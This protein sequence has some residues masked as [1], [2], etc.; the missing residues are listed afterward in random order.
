MPSLGYLLPTRPGGSKSFGCPETVPIGNAVGGIGI[1]L[2]TNVADRPW[3]SPDSAASQAFATVNG[4]CGSIKC[5]WPWKPLWWTHSIGRRP[6]HDKRR[7]WR[8]PYGTPETPQGYQVRNREKF[9][10]YHYDDYGGGGEKYPSQMAFA[11]SSLATV[12]FYSARATKDLFNTTAWQRFAWD[13]RKLRHGRRLKFSHR[14]AS[15]LMDKVNQH[16][17]LL[18]VAQLHIIKSE[19]SEVRGT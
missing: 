9:C 15:R 18:I 17:T 10:A 16:A 1:G 19:L 11:L 13:Y 4:I 2:T 14:S 3:S 8:D 5:W 6:L 12:S 7:Q